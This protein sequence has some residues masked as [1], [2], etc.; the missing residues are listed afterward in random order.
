VKA[1]KKA[2][3][4]RAPRKIWEKLGQDMAEP[5][6]NEK[7]WNSDFVDKHRR[8]INDCDWAARQPKGKPRYAIGDVLEFKAGG[9]GVVTDVSWEPETGWPSSYSLDPV[10]GMKFHPRDICAWHYE[11]D[12]ERRLAKSPLHRLEGRK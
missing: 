3:N 8:G 6:I 10:K 4:I 7:Y 12:F 5:S 11:L 1:S 9:F 2:M